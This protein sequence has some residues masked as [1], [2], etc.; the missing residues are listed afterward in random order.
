MTKP[1]GSALAWLGTLGAERPQ[2]SGV[3]QARARRSLDHDRDE[4]AANL[5]DEIHL[6]A[7]GRYTRPYPGRIQPSV[8]DSTH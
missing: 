1:T 4:L 6:L 7:H 2:G 5:D 3:A 8:H